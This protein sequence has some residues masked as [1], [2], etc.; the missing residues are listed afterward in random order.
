M[1]SII[2][3]LFSALVLLSSCVYDASSGFDPDLFIPENPNFNSDIHAQWW[4]LSTNGSPQINLYN[5]QS[6]RVERSFRVPAQLSNPQALAFDGESLWVGGTGSNAAVYQLNPADGSIISIVENIETKGLS[7]A[8]G[9]V[10]YLNGNTVRSLPNANGESASLPVSI[11][12][13]VTDFSMSDTHLFTVN[14]N[15]GEVKKYRLNA[16]SEEASFWTGIDGAQNISTIDN[17][18]NIVTESNAFCT[19][20]ADNG[21]MN[22]DIPIATPTDVTA[23]APNGPVQ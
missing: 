7:Y 13:N 3:I 1:K 11:D 22:N 15:F 20:N 9:Q 23:I 5:H 4:V 19:F 21:N 17:S 14:S 12:G 18:F 6:V 10:W 16:T 2:P 8:N